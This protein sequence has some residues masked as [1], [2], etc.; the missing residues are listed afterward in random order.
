MEKLIK[1]LIK[2][3]AIRDSY[4]TLTIHDK[5]DIDNSDTTVSMPLREN[6]VD[7]TIKSLTEQ[8]QNWS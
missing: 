5:K 6:N 4:V 7:K 2:E 1:Q 3:A 8:V